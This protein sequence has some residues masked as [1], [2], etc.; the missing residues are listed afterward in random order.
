MHPLG[1]MLPGVTEQ[2]RGFDGLRAGVE[3]L[4][5][6]VLRGLEV[7]RAGELLAAARVQTVEGVVS[8]V[9]GNVG[10]LG[11]VK[12]ARRWAQG[13]MLWFGLLLLLLDVVVVV[14]CNNGR[15]RFRCLWL[16]A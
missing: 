11:R 7:E 13:L 5:A 3:V 4:H 15:L 1:R 10:R 9:H 8:P 14:V 6:N 2:F 12:G 16:D